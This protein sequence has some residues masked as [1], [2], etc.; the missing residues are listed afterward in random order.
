[1]IFIFSTGFDHEHNRHD[2][3]DYITLQAPTSN[4]T[5]CQNHNYDDHDPSGVHS[6]GTAYDYCSVLHYGPGSGTQCRIA[7]TQPITCSVKGQQITEIG[8]SMGLSPLDIEE[9][10][11]RYSC[12]GKNRC[13]N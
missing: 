2:R 13:N 5:A 10:N 11:K 3:D 7:A 1:M 4:P 8:Q 12:D 9:I 6:Y